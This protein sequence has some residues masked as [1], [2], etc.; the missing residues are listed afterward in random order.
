MGPP[1]DSEQWKINTIM[2]NTDKK[3]MDKAA[4]TIEKRMEEGGILD[5]SGKPDV[6]NCIVLNWCLEVTVERSKQISQGREFHSLSTTITK[7]LFKVK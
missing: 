2:R 4:V 1:E 3:T 5:Y 6:Q 7:A